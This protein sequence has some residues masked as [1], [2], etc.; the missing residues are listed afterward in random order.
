[1]CKT[2]ICIPKLIDPDEQNERI[3]KEYIEGPTIYEL[4]YDELL[5]VQ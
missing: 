5:R 4:V 2:G 3:I 1:M